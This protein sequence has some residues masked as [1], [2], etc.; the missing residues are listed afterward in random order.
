MI[1]IFSFED[2]FVRVRKRRWAL[3]RAS[4]L[5]LQDKNTT[6]WLPTF[7]LCSQLS[8]LQ[9][10]HINHFYSLS[11]CTV[12]I[13]FLCILQVHCSW[14]PLFFHT[15]LII[16]VVLALFHCGIRA[17]QHSGMC[18]IIGGWPLGSSQS[19]LCNL[20]HFPTFHDWPQCPA[21]Q[22]PVSTLRGHISHVASL[23]IKTKSYGPPKYRA[24]IPNLYGFFDLRHGYCLCSK[25][26]FMPCF[27]KYHQQTEGAAAVNR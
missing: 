10:P 13:H 5:K 25:W 16:S 2:T 12:A 27:L 15:L 19:Q 23:N 8:P 22:W 17:L 3:K 7:V 20:S 11:F 21:A 1:F 9:S 14:S 18:E 24:A 26:F 4:A 6:S